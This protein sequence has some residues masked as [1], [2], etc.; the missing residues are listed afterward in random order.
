MQMITAIVREHYKSPRDAEHLIKDYLPL[1]VYT[2]NTMKVSLEE[3]ILIQF[4]IRLKELN[5]VSVNI[6]SEAFDKLKKVILSHE[7]VVELP[8][9]ERS[10]HADTSVKCVREND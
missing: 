4:V 7:Q 3:H 10:N 6:K 1:D 2:L 5:V 8:K 9:I